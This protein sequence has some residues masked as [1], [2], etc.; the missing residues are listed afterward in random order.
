MVIFP[1]NS[2]IRL[3]ELRGNHMENKDYEI[4]WL[5]ENEVVLYTQYAETT[6]ENVETLITAINGLV[7]TSKRDKV[8]V[9]VIAKSVKGSNVPITGVARKFQT[10]SSNKWG[11]TIVIG[12]EGIVR[13]LAQIL[14]QLVR[15]E[16]RFAKDVD[17]ALNVLYRIY[18]DLP[19]QS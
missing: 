4:S 17:E 19:R 12:A 15:I 5:I 16:V 7:D 8:P 1:Y 6:L 11:F 3:L 2:N 13:F 18:P 10:M 9:I 14:F